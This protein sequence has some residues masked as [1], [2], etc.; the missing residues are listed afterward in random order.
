[1]YGQAQSTL[2][3]PSESVAI[4]ATRRLFMLTATAAAAYGGMCIHRQAHAAIVQTDTAKLPPLPLQA[5]IRSRYVSNINGL[6]FHVLEAGFEDKGRP[7]VLL[8][9]GYPELAFGWRKVML[10]LASAG[11]H[12]LAPDM[13]GYGRT[14]GW[15]DSYDGDV[16]AFRHTN[17]VRDA[18]GLVSAFGYRSAAVVGRDA[19]SPVAAYCALCV[20]LFIVSVAIQNVS[21]S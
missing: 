18:L 14:T 5:G 8:L 10:P 11:F 19:G 21:A 1:M 17:L 12:V 9:H 13:R 16:F 15:D 4:A 6:T 2:A 7:C 20:G 3:S